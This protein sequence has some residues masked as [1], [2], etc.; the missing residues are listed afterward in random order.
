M[1]RD[2]S[3]DPTAA[4]VYNRLQGLA[5]ERG[6]ATDELF[7]LYLLERSLYRWANSRLADQFVLKGGTLLAAYNLRRATRDIDV[8]ALAVDNDADTLAALVREICQIDSDDGVTFDLDRLDVRTIREG[9]TYEGLRLRIPAGLGRAQLVLRL[10][11]NVGDPITP[12]PR[13]GRHHPHHRHPPDRQRRTAA[14][15]HSDRRLPQRRAR[16]PGPPHGRTGRATT[17]PL[18]TLAGSDGTSRR[19][20]GVRT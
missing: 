7:Q 1:T 12:R 4:E 8:Q 3:N 6:R 15:L 9:A 13:R 20:T 17:G 2:A 19:T 14:R 5:R 16:H 11:V 10:D 18:D